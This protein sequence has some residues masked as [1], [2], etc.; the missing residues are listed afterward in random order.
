LWCFDNRPF[1]VLLA[2]DERTDLCGEIEAY[3]LA[4]DATPRSDFAP[5]TPPAHTF[6]FAKT[7]TLPITLPAGRYMLRA[8][9]ADSTTAFA[10]VRVLPTDAPAV[11]SAISPNDDGIL[12]F[13]WPE[14][15]DPRTLQERM[16]LSGDNAIHYK[17]VPAGTTLKGFA[18]LKGHAPTFI[19]ISSNQGLQVPQR[20]TSPFFE[21]PIPQDACGCLDVFLFAFDRGQ[22]YK[23][24][25]T[26]EVKPPQTLHLE[27]NHIANTV[28]PNTEA[29]WSLTVNDPTA[30]VAIVCYNA[31]WESDIERELRNFDFG[32][33]D[34]LVRYINPEFSVKSPYEISDSTFSISEFAPL[35]ICNPDLYARAQER[36][37][38]EVFHPEFWGHTPYEAE[39]FTQWSSGYRGKMR[40]PKLRGHVL[41]HYPKPPTRNFPAAPTSTKALSALAQSDHE[42]HNTILWLPDA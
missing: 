30:N 33:F 39:P 20:L 9:T 34:T 15:E 7:G 10:P 29:T 25:Q 8:K 28:A 35:D 32:A 3:P 26:I 23:V 27:A 38:D 42:T 1:E 19:T 36:H 24:V 41:R 14:K 13:Q 17:P 11:T 40:G 4:A 18:A 22:W 2:S 6:P 5:T 12:R 16:S 31:A 37:R 21:L